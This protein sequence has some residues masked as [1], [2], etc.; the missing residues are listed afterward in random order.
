[1]PVTEFGSVM[2]VRPL[3]PENADS[4]TFFTELGIVVLLHPAMS[5]LSDFLM[6][7]LQLL[8]ESYTVFPLSTIMEV[9]PLQPEKAPD[10]M[11]VTEL[12][13]VMEVRLLQSWNALNIDNQRFVL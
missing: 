10:F 12:G 6:I 2:E 4:S 1:M 3:R 8:R 9:S 5:A 11:F 13:I 7:A